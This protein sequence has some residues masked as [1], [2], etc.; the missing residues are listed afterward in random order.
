[1][2]WYINWIFVILWGIS[3]FFWLPKQ[4]IKDWIIC[5]L[6]RALFSGFTDSFV[7][8]YNLIEYPNRFF[9]EVFKISVLFNFLVF[10]T[11]CVFYNQT[12]YR[13]KL[14]GIIG[15]AILYSASITLLE[16]WFEKNTQLIVYHKWWTWMHTFTGLILFFLMGRSV[17]AIIRKYSDERNYW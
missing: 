6:F 14:S 15:Q 10:P 2:E 13:S 17:L 12:T 11:L 1:M 7:V 5:Y 3:F 8:A 16:S 9:P 4:P